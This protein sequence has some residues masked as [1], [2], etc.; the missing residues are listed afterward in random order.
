MST[1]TSA[2]VWTRSHRQARAAVV[3]RAPKVLARSATD[4]QSAN[5]GPAAP[6]GRAAV[7]ADREESS[8]SEQTERSRRSRRQD[9]PFA[10]AN[11]THRK[12]T[13][14]ARSP[15]PSKR[16]TLSKQKS[17]RTSDVLLLWNGTRTLAPTRPALPL[18]GHETLGQS[19]G[20]SRAAL[21]QSRD[22]LA[23]PTPACQCQRP[24]ATNW[25]TDSA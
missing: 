3:P 17:S 19:P 18:H 8:A 23:A 20:A 7:R 12:R 5:D 25:M 14:F 1:C 4:A 22:L 21:L 10:K 6:K 11:D 13:R 2:R 15:P 9:S 24:P 16:P